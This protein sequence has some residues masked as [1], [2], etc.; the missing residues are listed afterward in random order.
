MPGIQLY[1]TEVDELTVVKTA[2]DRGWWLIPDLDYSSDQVQELRSIEQFK[3]ARS[4]ERHFFIVSDFFLC[5]P[6]SLRKITKRG[7]TVFYVSPS[8]GGPCLEFLGGGVFV[9]DATTEQRIRPGFL[10]FSRHYWASDLSQRFQ[11]P[12]QLEIA[13]KLLAG[14]IKKNSLRIKPGKSVFWLGNDAR[15]E[16]QKG[17]RLVGFENW[18]LSDNGD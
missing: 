18:L 17:T 14:V 8:E 1:Q 5:S 15:S 11:S 7:E 16:L 9:D 3:R 10:A 4:V 13:F 6:L 2:L 12:P